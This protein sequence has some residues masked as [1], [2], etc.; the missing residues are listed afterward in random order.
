MPRVA[1]AGAV[2]RARRQP[3]GDLL[4]GADLR[5]FA[6]QEFVNFSDDSTAVTLVPRDAF[7][8]RMDLD[9][10]AFEAIG[11]DQNYK[12]VSKDQDGATDFCFR[13]SLFAKAGAYDGAAVVASAASAH[14]PLLSAPG[15]RPQGT[16]PRWSVSVDPQ[17]AVATCLKPADDPAAGGV[18]LRLWE[19]AGQSGPATIGVPGIRRAIRTDLLERDQSEAPIDNEQIHVDLPAHG[20]CAVRIFPVDQ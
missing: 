16:A 8:L 19:T 9:V 4:P 18:I 2:V 5:R 20:Y 17:R 6:V 3:A 1:A 13:Y 7:C 14:T 12:E 15:R 10:P 11:N